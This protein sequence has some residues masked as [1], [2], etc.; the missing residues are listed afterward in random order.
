MTSYESLTDKHKKF[1]DCFLDCSNYTKAY[2]EAYACNNYNTAKTNGYQL[3]KLPEVRAAILEKL[4]EYSADKAET[5][6][7]IIQII[8][9]DLSNYIGSN[10]K[11]DIESLNEDGYGWMITGIKQL[12]F[13][14]EITLMSKDQALLSLTKI[15]QLLDDK[16]TV[17]VNINQELAT[18]QKLASELSDLRTKLSEA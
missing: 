11:V 4:K 15:H 10:L 14:T 7:K 9:F 18:K 17:N 1:V 5:L 3:A 12:K 8:D 6:H 16:A 13:G 2:K